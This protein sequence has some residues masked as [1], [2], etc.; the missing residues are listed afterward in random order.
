MAKC[1]KIW[2]NGRFSGQM[3]PDWGN[4][5]RAD[6]A[7]LGSIGLRSFQNSFES[8]WC[9]S[10]FSCI[11]SAFTFLISL[12]SRFLAVHASFQ[13][14]MLFDLLA[15]LS[16]KSLSCIFSRISFVIQGSFRF[17]IFKIFSGHSS[18]IVSKTISIK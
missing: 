13:S 3:W 7:G 10:R 8:F 14:L 5:V 4:T 17:L 2:K 16:R 9:C 6:I 18:S 12:F 15:L 1:G 11:K